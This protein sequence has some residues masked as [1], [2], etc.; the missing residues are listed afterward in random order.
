[1]NQKMITPRNAK[2]TAFTTN[3]ILII[4]APF[5]TPLLVRRGVCRPQIP[6]EQNT[7]LLV[8][9]SRIHASVDSRII[10]NRLGHVFDLVVAG[11]SG[12]GVS[13]VTEARQ[14][15]RAEN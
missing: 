5:T 13:Y 3:P 6:F 9:V 12:T 2:T 10:S 1:D 8:R 14:H 11:P 4:Y 7:N 15:N